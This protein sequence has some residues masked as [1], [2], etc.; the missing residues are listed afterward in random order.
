MSV[1]GVLQWIASTDLSTAISSGLWLFPIIETIHV[2]AITTVVGSILMVDLRLLGVA[3]RKTA[4]TLIARELLP[5]TWTAFTIAAISGAMMFSSKPSVYLAD[6]QFELKFL[7]MA[8]A[9]INMLLFHRGAYRRVMQW[10]NELPPPVGA[11]LAGG[12]SIALWCAV[13]FMGRWT[14]FTAQ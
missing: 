14:G 11:R 9:G 12:I 10:D 5:Y 8:L 2:L 6:R 13:V 1:N 3:T 7:F 4:M